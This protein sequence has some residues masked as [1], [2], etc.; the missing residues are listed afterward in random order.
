MTEE[1][2]QRADIDD[3]LVKA[4]FHIDDGRDHTQR[5]IHRMRRNQHI[6]EGICPLLPPAP[7]VAEV[8]LTP[9]KKARNKR[10]KE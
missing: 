9:V 5:I 2:R 10:G 4:T 1:H 3:V 7:K 8:K 6:H